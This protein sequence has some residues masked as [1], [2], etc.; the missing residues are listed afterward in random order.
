MLFACRLYHSPAERCSIASLLLVICFLLVD[1]AQAQRHTISG[2]VRDAETGEALIGATVGL[3]AVQV[4]TT[5]NRYGF[6]SLTLPGDSIT[7]V[8]SYLGYR[9][10]IHRFHLAADTTLN[11][12]LVPTAV[13]I[14]EITVEAERTQRIEETTRMSTIGIP[15]QQIQDMPALLGER[16]VLKAIQLLP[17]IQSGAEGTSGLYVRGGGP[18]QNLILLDGVPV[19]NAAHLFG[20]FSV[21]NTDAIQRVEVVKGGFPARYGGR[22]SSVIEIDMKEGNMN[23]FAA[24]GGIGVISSRLTLEAPIVKDRTSFVISGRRTYIDLLTRPFMKLEDGVG[25]Y[26]FYDVNAKVNHTISSRDRVYLSLYTGDDRFSFRMRNNHS[27]SQNSFGWGNTTL[28]LR[29]NHLFSN[30]LF[31]NLTL[32]RSEYEFSLSSDER[33]RDGSHLLRYTSGIEDLGARYDLDFMP[34]PQ[35]AIKAGI[36]V[37]SHDFRPGAAHFRI[38]GD[39]N[40][41]VYLA[42]VRSIGAVES[43]AYI[44]DDM[45]ISRRLGANVGLHASMFSVNERH[46][47]SVQPRL[48]LRYSL[49]SNWAAKASF[50]SMQQHLHLLTNSGMGLPT[51]LWVP[52]TDRVRPQVSRQVAVGVGGTVLDGAYEVSAETYYKTMNNLIEYREGAN[53]LNLDRD[54]QDLVTSGSGTSYGGEVFVQRRVGRVTGWLGYTLSWTGRQFEELNDGLRFPYKY[55]RRQSPAPNPP[56]RAPPPLDLAA[57]WIYG[58]GNAITV[59]VGRMAHPNRHGGWTWLD[60]R[61]VYSDRNAYRMAAYHRL[62]LS[63]NWRFRIRRGEH[64][65]NTSLFNAYNRKNPFFIFFDEH[66]GQ[67]VAKQVSLFPTIP[68]ITYHFNF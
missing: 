64:T 7:L 67:T 29:W 38:E 37:V 44:E 18:D 28:A 55:D 33:Y 22:L 25:G 39:Q 66:Q 45:R 65:L 42:P 16:D 58:T 30:R 20:F 17:G 27:D 4:G 34:S 1:A 59:P 31:G 32:T 12:R 15:V 53:F 62:D 51:D 14:E 5:T 6:Y 23:R 68:S 3:P 54:W 24:Q 8:F 2:H 47:T 60:N 9:P 26:Y 50:A 41:D 13:G 46:Y 43:S 19:Y 57:T 11:V 35:H 40:M 21:F 49:T 48:A 36:A 63:M 10:E 56:S 61:F 52:A